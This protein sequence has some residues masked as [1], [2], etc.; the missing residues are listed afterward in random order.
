MGKGFNNYMTKKFFHPSSKENIK[1]VWMAQ[2]K[3]EFEKKK[4][5][6]LLNQYQK[7]QET[8]SNR[9]LLGD[10]KAK[11]GLSFMYDAPPGLKKK[12]DEKDVET[13]VKFEWQRKYNAPREQ[14]AKNDDEIRDQPFGIEVRNVRCIK[15]RKW[16][17]VNTDKICPLFNRDLTAEPPQP[18]TSAAALVEGMKEDGFKLKQSILGRMAEDPSAEHEKLLESGD[19]DDPEVK[20]LK[21][22]SAKQKKKLLKKLN[23]IQEGKVKKSKKDKK[24]KKKK[25]HRSSSDSEDESSRRKKKKRNEETDSDSSDEDSKKR[26]DRSS[27]NIDLKSKRRDKGKGKMRRYSSSPDKRSSR[28]RQRNSKNY[29]QKRYES[30]S[31]SD[32][33]SSS[34]TGSDFYEQKYNKQ[35]HDSRQKERRNRSPDN[36]TDTKDRVRD[37][38]SS[39]ISKEQ[40]YQR[41]SRSSSRSP[42]K[43]KSRRNR[44]MSNERREQS[45]HR[46]TRS[47]SRSP[48]KNKSRRNRSSSNEKREQSRRRYTRSRSRSPDANKSRRKRSSSNEKREQSQ[49]RY[50]RSRSRSPD[51]NKSKRN[52]SRSDERRSYSRERYELGSKYSNGSQRSRS[53]SPDRQ[54]SRYSTYGGRASVN[55]PP[56][57]GWFPTAEL[58]PGVKDKRSRT[59]VWIVGSSIVYW[60]HKRASQL[61]D[62]N[63]GV[64]TTEACVEWYGTRGMRWNALLP[65]LMELVQSKPPPDVLI[66]YV[67]SNDVGYVKPMDLVKMI[68]NDLCTIKEMCP[69]TQ[70]IYNE[71]LSRINWRGAPTNQD[72]EQQRLTINKYVKPAVESM[73]GFMIH[74]PD[75]RNVNLSLYR[76]DGVH[77][78]DRG[79]DIFNGNVADT[80]RA[81]LLKNK[82]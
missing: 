39:R 24:Q 20:F 25:K 81:A 70:L 30:S 5:E 36:R 19:E 78:N 69:E 66:L 51:T 18:S 17:H 53:R 15:C 57:K 34:N 71:I 27:S 59:S 22:L 80:V 54:H 40:S 56:V 2:Q 6:E 62:I 46:Y 33:D 50:A 76:D 37:S 63:L 77:L 65:K 3:T 11:L 7:E 31:D 45:H 68:K 4:Q 42:S 43:N 74:H 49:R 55:T 82:L 8:Y 64:K 38:K 41:H 9:A 12:E 47:K 73:G 21:S 28:E 61:R 32:S 10:E 13:E 75:I 26:R 48:D 58:T 1:R 14:Y 16:G 79:Y 23:K 29:K 72:G 44:S 67:G 60:A 35:S 52:R